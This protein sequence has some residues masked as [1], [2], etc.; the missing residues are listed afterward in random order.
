MSR[1]LIQ[2]CVFLEFA[3]AAGKESARKG[4]TLRF[5]RTQHMPHR[6]LQKS[7]LDWYQQ[8]VY[9]TIWVREST[10]GGGTGR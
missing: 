5:P 6:L 2:H 8:L 9:I 7:Q 3:T 4:S 1:T 10:G